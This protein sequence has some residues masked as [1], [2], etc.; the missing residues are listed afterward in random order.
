MEED[1]RSLEK[2]DFEGRVV[3][4]GLDWS[5]GHKKCCK[6]ESWLV[7]EG[8]EEGKFLRQEA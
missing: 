5:F 4:V 1:A 8:K 2:K 7:C 6:K 3:T